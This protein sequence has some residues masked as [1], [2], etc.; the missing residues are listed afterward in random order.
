MLEGLGLR[1]E[2]STVNQIANKPP[3]R[4]KMY[5]N[6]TSQLVAATQGLHWGMQSTRNQAFFS[7]KE[8]QWLQNVASLSVRNHQQHEEPAMS[9]AGF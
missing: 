8:P 4:S 6:Q 1:G 5:E 3:G 2:L 9:Q 7:T